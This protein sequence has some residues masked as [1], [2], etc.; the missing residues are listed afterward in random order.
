MAWSVRAKPVLVGQLGNTIALLDWRGA[1]VDSGEHLG[2]VARYHDVNDGWPIAFLHALLKRG[3]E[4]LWVFDANAPA[5][6]CAGD[7]R[8]IHLLE[9][10]RLVAASHHRVLQGFDVPGGGVVDNDDGQS[11]AD[12]PRAFQFAKGHVEPAVAANCNHRQ[13]RYSQTRANAPWQPIADGS[14]SAVRDKLATGLFGIVEQAGPM[15]REAAVGNEDRVARQGLVELAAKPGHM[16]RPVP[17]IEPR[18]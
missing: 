2:R 3:S 18:R 5:A 4:R 12:A 15:S 11:T 8:V 13:V 10:G 14:E 9:V 6:H 7:R 1:V 17:R 16:H